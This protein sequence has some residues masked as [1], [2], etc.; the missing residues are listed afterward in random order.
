MPATPLS[1]TEGTPSSIPAATRDASGTA[2]AGA[3]DAP[4]GVMSTSEGSQPLKALIERASSWFG[5]TIPPTTVGKKP[6]ACSG[7]CNQSGHRYYNG[8]SSHDIVDGA[9]HCNGCK[10]VV[11]GCTSPRNKSDYCFMHKRV[12]EYFPKSLQCARAGRRLS[13]G[14]LP[15]DILSFIDMWPVV[16]HDPLLA[17]VAAVLKEPSALKAGDLQILSTRATTLSLSLLS[18]CGEVC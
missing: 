2:L 14:L 18:V 10:C 12:W 13:V 15:C 5:D 1:A 4:H 9:K 16:A 17:V 3:S 7:P 11:L 6:C 8:C